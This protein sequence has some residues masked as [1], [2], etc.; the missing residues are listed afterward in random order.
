MK[1]IAMMCL[2]A[3]PLFAQQA[4][5]RPEAGSPVEDPPELTSRNGTLETT[6][7][8]RS[9][10]DAYSQTRYCYVTPHGAQSPTLRVNPGDT[11]ILHLK[12]E[13]GQPGTSPMSGCKAAQMS[14]QSTN[15]HFHGLSIP[16]ACHQDDVLNTLLPEGSAFDYRFTIPADQSPGLYWYHPHPHGFTEAQVLGG[17]SGALIVQGLEQKAKERILILRDQLQPGQQLNYMEP[18]EESEKDVSI[19]FVPVTAPLFTPATIKSSAGQREFWRVLNASA[20]TY[21]DLEQPMDLI[22]L[23]GAS[24]PQVSHRNDI[25]IPPGGRAEFLVTGANGQLISKAYDTGTGGEKTPR[26]VLAN[27]VA[28]GESFGVST[29]EARVIPAPPIQLKPVRTRRLYLSE[30]LEDVTDPKYYITEEGANPKLFDMM[31][32]E[33]DITAEQGTVEDWL[34]EN[35]AREAHTF[36]IHQLHFQ[37]LERDGLPTD[38]ILMD[39][40]D[41]PFW[42][43]DGPYPSVKLR[44]DFRSPL[45]V[46][47]FVYHCHILEHEDNGMMGRI[48]IV[49]GK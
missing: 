27:I 18:G 26:R 3:A 25:L 24:L 32:D 22:A 38:P 44:M 8:F 36:H 17:A 6:L 35:R 29:R 28:R 48:R 9:S 49:R 23:D 20:D 45:I 30:D 33:P 7:F 41:L 15:L 4:C 43:G 14:P 40:I 11:V 34:I 46:G 12:N 10:Q 13:A 19:N 5:P 21:F 42:K 1:L 2:F 37:L 47:T 31:S 16:P 39:T